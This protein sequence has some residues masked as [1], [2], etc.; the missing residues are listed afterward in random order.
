[1]LCEAWIGSWGGEGLA[2][3]HQC[4]CVGGYVSGVTDPCLV[5]AGMGGCKVRIG[6]VEVSCQ[7]TAISAE[8][9][10]GFFAELGHARSDKGVYIA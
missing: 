5:R 2:L 4:E 3:A 7:S 6:D 9:I 8:I 10:F 1:M